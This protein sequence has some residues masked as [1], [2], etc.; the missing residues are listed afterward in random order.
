[1]LWTVLL[2]C[3][4]Q[5]S[6]FFKPKQRSSIYDSAALVV[7]Y[8]AGRWRIILCKCLALIIFAT[9]KSWID[10]IK[11]KISRFIFFS[12][13]LFYC[14]AK[15][16]FASTTETWRPRLWQLGRGDGSN[17]FTKKKK[18]KTGKREDEN[19][20]RKSLDRS[21]IIL[22]LYNHRPNEYRGLGRFFSSFSSF[23]PFTWIY[24]TFTFRK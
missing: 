7:Q 24:D 5:Y 13:C 14:L 2:C 16:W 3:K 10:E 8:S 1:M 12:T 21:F 22:V 19:E 18:K 23:L 20:K 6:T 15:Y 4:L 9:I 11:S 17:H